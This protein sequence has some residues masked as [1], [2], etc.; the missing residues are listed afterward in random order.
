MIK[1]PTKKALYTSEKTSAKNRGMTFEVLIDETNA[2][3]R[4]MNKAIIYKKPTPI[5]IVRVD[6]PRRESA[7]ITEAYYKTP[8]TTDYNGIYKGL[9]ID[10]DVKESK[11]ETSFPLKNI[12][13]HQI[14]HL[15]NVHE[16]GGVA[17]ILIYLKAHDEIYFL[18]YKALEK[19]LK[20][21]EKGRKSIAYDE[22]KENAIKIPL[23]YR[24]SVPYLNAIDQYLQKD[25]SQTL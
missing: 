21:S 20:R 12:H 13:T 11:S 7:K 23:S 5:Q 18:S 17:F 4:L 2:F 3:Y 24:P 10:F 22:L 1:Y 25:K 19:F 16:H 14:D 9:Y 15:K 8:S 6:Y